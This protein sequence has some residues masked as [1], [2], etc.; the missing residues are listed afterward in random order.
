RPK[1]VP[2]FV[3]KVKIGGFIWLFLFKNFQS[4]FPSQ[5]DKP[6]FVISAQ[7]PQNRGPAFGLGLRIRCRPC[8]QTRRRSRNRRRGSL[9]G[10]SL[11][12]QLWARWQGC[13]LIPKV[14]RPSKTRAKRDRW[15][16][17]LERFAAPAVNRS[18]R[19][20]ACLLRREMVRIEL[21]R[22]SFLCEKIRSPVRR[23]YRGPTAAT[24]P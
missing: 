1:K 19:G 21:Q 16:L 24:F 17:V 10:G 5:D 2:V 15:W 11:N 12:L 13:L 7:Q 22:R 4:S 18:I 3:K 6:L 23:R 8:V 20:C 9:L 14:T